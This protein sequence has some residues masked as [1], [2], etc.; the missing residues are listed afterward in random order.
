MTE[1]SLMRILAIRLLTLSITGSLAQ[2]QP[3]NPQ[4][5]FDRAVADFFEA[6]ISES[7]TGFDR[8]A[9]LSP[10]AAPQLWQRGIALYY[11]GR[12]KD[13]RS[14]FESH[15]TVNP[16]DVENAAWHFL[17]VARA[18][19]PEK[20]KAALLPVGE[21]S[22]VPM[23]EIYQMF[24]GAL[25]PDKI[26]AAAGDQPEA[27]FYAHLYV[28]LYHEAL[29]DK[30]RALEHIRTASDARYSMGGYMHRVAR[31]HLQVSSSMSETWTFDRLD[32]LG[33]HKTTLL[34]QPRVVN[35]PEG[36]AIEFD[37]VDDAIFLEVHP[38]AGAETFTWEVIF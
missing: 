6:R 28:G 20:A 27:Q 23:R 10:R 30:A 35:T 25:T 4:A 17:C 1:S 22:R 13:C 7:V 11:A 15:R 29:G 9:R 38:L 24:R 18:E 21:D 12:Y 33:T 31:V 36:K 14:Q 32:R 16:A 19:S 37:G 8:V 5:I 26:I 34:G 3:D 2:S